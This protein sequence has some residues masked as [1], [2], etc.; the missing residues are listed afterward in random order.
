M[1]TAG[2]YPRIIAPWMF[3]CFYFN[4]FTAIFYVLEKQVADLWFSVLILVTG[5]IAVFVGGLFCRSSPCY[6]IIVNSRSFSG[7]WVNMYTLKISGVSV[8]GAMREIIRYFII[9]RIFCL[10]LIIAKYYS[11]QIFTFDRYC[12][13]YIGAILCINH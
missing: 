5:V 2:V 6:G 12:Y 4:S 9:S 11:I 8:T 3:V 10:P 13:C 7:S 1:D